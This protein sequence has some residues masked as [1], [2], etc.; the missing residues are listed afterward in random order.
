MMPLCLANCVF[1]APCS[2]Q[3]GLHSSIYLQNVQMSCEALCNRDDK[4]TAFIWHF[5]S[6]STTQSILQHKSTFTHSYT[7]THTLMAG[8]FN[9]QRHPAH[10][11]LMHVSTVIG[12]NLGFSVNCFMRELG[13]YPV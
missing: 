6:L 1:V 2:V 10:Q 11:E 4:W 5:Y 3:P 12:S 7:H 13:H 8:G 9:T